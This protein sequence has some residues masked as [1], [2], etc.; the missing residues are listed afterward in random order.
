MNK[1]KAT[2]FI[3]LLKATFV[4]NV[5]SLLL[6][7]IYLFYQQMN[8]FWNMYGVLMISTF[9]VNILFA[10]MEK[11]Q[12]V[13]SYTYLI[14]SALWMYMVLIINTIVSLNPFNMNSQSTI[15]ILMILSLFFLGGLLSYHC[16]ADV[17]KQDKPISSM[18][19][20]ISNRGISVKNGVI[21]FLSAILY[22][23][24]FLAISLLKVEKN[25]LIEA[26]LSEYAL[27]YAIAFL[28]I[29]T[30]I[31]KLLNRKKYHLYYSIVFTIT[32]IMFVIFILPF[33]YIP[34]LMNKAEGNYKKVFSAEYKANPIYSTAAFRKL[35]FSLPEYFFG[36]PSKSYQLKENVLFYLGTEGVDK[37][38]ELH[39]DVYMPEG[40][41]TKL[42]GENSVLIRI[43][44]GGW[45]S[46]DKGAFNFAQMN[47]YF[48]AQGYVV[49]DIQ[50]GLNN[51]KSYFNIAPVPKTI[52]NDFSIDDM[53]RHIGIFTNYLAEHADDYQANLDSVFISGGSAGG[54]LALV[55]GLA[56]SSNKYQDLLNSKL[57]VKGV[58][59]FYP[60]N[61]LS[62]ELDIAGEEALVDPVLLVDKK[63]PPCLIFQGSHDGLVNSNIS[64][65]FRASYLKAGNNQCAIIEMP[66]G[67]HASD[68]YFSGYYNQVFLY[69]M[70]R[71]LYQYK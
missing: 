70:E 68:F 10:T 12:K 65:K 19:S 59:P 36:T 8:F 25:Y 56:L 1:N 22:G 55:T 33:F 44:G 69:Y 4:L 71:F 41:A 64:E 37:G 18:D 2:N 35:P 34:S 27:F 6:G 50:Y 52:S 23:G 42:P 47:K 43:H 21:I 45:T 3:P 17:K 28:S 32:I 31:M 54:H 26:F 5:L 16:I 30:L 9:L 67:G 63:S 62:L 29:G 60:A 51:F 14:L 39:F 66:F 53:V 7:I 48:A 13:L 58:I 24:L 40:D 61:K 57:S 38:L 46:G 49:F 15:S 20:S 11:K